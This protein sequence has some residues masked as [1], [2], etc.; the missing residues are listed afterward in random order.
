[1]LKFS[2]IIKQQ[3]HIIQVTFIDILNMLIRINYLRWGK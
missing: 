2:V 3:K 1:M